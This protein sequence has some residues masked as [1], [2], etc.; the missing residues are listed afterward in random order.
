MARHETGPHNPSQPPQGHSHDTPSWM[1]STLQMRRAGLQI[2]WGCLGTLCIL[3]GLYGVW[4]PPAGWHRESI[5]TVMGGAAGVGI[6][7]WLL[8]LWITIKSQRELLTHVAEWIGW[9]GLTLYLGII[10]AYYFGGWKAPT[11]ALV[12]LLIVARGI[13][14][15][16]G[17]RYFLLVA[18]S[19]WSLYVLSLWM[20]SFASVDPSATTRSLLFTN[21]TLAFATVL[22]A[23]TAWLHQLFFQL[24]SQ[25]DRL[26]RYQLQQRINQRGMSQVFLAWNRLLAQPCIVKRMPFR[27]T[28]RDRA[29]QAFRREAE[30][31]LKIQDPHVVRILDFGETEHDLYLVMESLQGINLFALQQLQSP[32]PLART[33]HL[34]LQACRGLAAVHKQGI[35]HR[36]IKP[37]NLFVTFDEQHYD[38]LKVLDFGIACR[39][40]ATPAELLARGHGRN[41]GTPAYM[42]PERFQGENTLAS[43]IYALG[44]VFYNLL[45]GE[46]L[47][48]ADSISDYKDIHEQGAFS[49]RDLQARAPH[50]PKELLDILEK[51]LAVAPSERYASAEALSNALEACQANIG[52]WT[53][54]QAKEAWQ[55]LQRH[56]STDAA[57]EDPESPLKSTPPPVNAQPPQ[58]APDLLDAAPID[59]EHA[60]HKHSEHP[61]EALPSQDQ[62]RQAPKEPEQPTSEKEDE[63]P[64]EGDEPQKKSKNWFQPPQ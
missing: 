55:Q 14:L 57:Q 19:I 51:A 18:C 25:T 28:Q 2:L 43:D 3:W 61:T 42:A 59:P 26:G 39:L 27:T 13:F 58:E 54:E 11:T 20:L 6:G 60:H 56:I 22:G 4:W 1:L 33:L 50:L 24:L 45:T 36:D 47:V 10:S 53:Q 32:L 48:K 63:Q 34:M 35:L 62:S 9:L 21:A 8:G 31:S 16:G 30:L 7:L 49:R 29:I 17:W 52:T 46:T 15:P 37:S 40:A 64:S 38:F 12:A 5:L 41:P 44:A 23:F